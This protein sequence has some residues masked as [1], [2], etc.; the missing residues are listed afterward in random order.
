MVHDDTKQTTETL[1]LGGDALVKVLTRRETV[2]ALSLSERSFKRL[3]AKG[4]IP[5]KTRLSDRRVGFRV[6]DIVAWLDAR[7]EKAGA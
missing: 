2:K 3:E 6:S 7:R 1:F 4:D 5:P